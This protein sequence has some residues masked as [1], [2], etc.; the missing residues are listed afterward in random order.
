[1]KITNEKQ[2]INEQEEVNPSSDKLE[3]L[4]RD[5][6]NDLWSAGLQYHEINTIIRIMDSSLEDMEKFVQDEAA[7]R[8]FGEEEEF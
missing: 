7:K 1:M 2:P 3:T 4:A 8:K 5:I 6:L